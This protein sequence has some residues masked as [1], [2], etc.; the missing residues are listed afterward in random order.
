MSEIVRP[1]EVKN[2]PWWVKKKITK[3]FLVHNTKDYSYLLGQ[4]KP[5]KETQKSV[6]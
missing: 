6:F 1:D 4:K 2:T 3:A 5:L